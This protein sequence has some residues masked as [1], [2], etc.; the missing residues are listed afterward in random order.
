MKKPRIFISHI[1]EEKDL[2]INFKEYLENKFQNKIEIFVSSDMDSISLGDEWFKTIMSNLEKCDLMIILCSSISIKRPW[3]NFEAGC[4]VIRKIPVIPICHS[5]LTLDKLPYPL[6]TLQSG[7]ISN[8]EDIEK[9]FR[10]IASINDTIIPDVNNHNF[11]KFINKFE[12]VTKNSFLAKNFD[13]VIKLLRQDLSS[14]RFSIITS[15]QPNTFTN[16][17]IDGSNKEFDFS[18]YTFEFKQIE[19]LFRFGSGRNGYEEIQAKIIYDLINKLA[20]DIQFILSNRNLILSQ[21]LTD[22]L[23]DFLFQKNTIDSWEIGRII[24]FATGNNQKYKE[25][26]LKDIRSYDKIPEFKGSHYLQY[27]FNYYND[28]KFYQNWIIEFGRQVSIKV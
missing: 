14:L 8:I 23:Y 12:I 17:L 6:K 27:F 16:S 21:E 20:T 11:F 28:L 22:L 24:S 18:K 10:K 15:T 7:K 1:T 19:Y 13:S 4:G 26:H 25:Q 2:A 9:L 5:D 3:I